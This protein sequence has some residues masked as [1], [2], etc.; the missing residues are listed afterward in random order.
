[1][2]GCAIILIINYKAVPE[3]FSLIFSTAFTARRVRRFPRSR[4]EGGDKVRVARGLF[5]NESGLAVRRLLRRRADKNSRQAGACFIDGNFLDTV[6]VCAMTGL[7]VVSSGE[8]TQ[9]LSG[10][11]S[12]RT[13]S[14]IS[15]CRSIV[16]TVDFSPSSSRR[17]WAGRITVKKPRSISSA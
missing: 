12:R 6:V 15:L 10:A 3:T 7:V 13:L 2:L 8:W 5:S 9:G 11:A 17:Y 1:V 4:H 14:R 16:L